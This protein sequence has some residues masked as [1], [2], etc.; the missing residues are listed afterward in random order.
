MI[1]TCAELLTLKTN[2]EFLIH[3]LE[4]KAG[5]WERVATLVERSGINFN[6][7]NDSSFVTWLKSPDGEEKHYVV[8]IFYDVSDDDSFTA[9]LNTCDFKK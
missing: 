3:L 8:V 4:V 2:E 1:D 9:L 5:Q 6:D 7:V